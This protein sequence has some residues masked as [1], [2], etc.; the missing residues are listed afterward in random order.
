MGPAVSGAIHPNFAKNLCFL[1]PFRPHCAIL[2][3][4]FQPIR[5]AGFVVIQQAKGIAYFGISGDCGKCETKEALNGGSSG[6]PKVREVGVDL[7]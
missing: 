6:R 4:N 2:K 5:W 1:R 7:T 3:S